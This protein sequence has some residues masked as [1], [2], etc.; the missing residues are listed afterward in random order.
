IATAGSAQ[1]NTQSSQ[2]PPAQQG[3]TQAPPPQGAA[4]PG[5]AQPGAKRPPQ[6]K[7]QPEFDAYQKAVALNDPAAMEA[8]ATDF[9]TTFPDS[10]LRKLLFLTNLRL[11]QSSNPDKTIEIGRKILA[12]DSDDPEALV[13]V[14]SVLAEKTRDTDLDKDQRLDE[15]LKMAQRATETINT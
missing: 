8:A 9:A 3:T 5:S 13:T 2:T 12:I 11:Y 15:A 1:S 4:Q 6:A 10:E 14:A 7:T